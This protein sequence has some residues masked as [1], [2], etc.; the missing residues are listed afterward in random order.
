MGAQR[1]VWPRFLA[2]HD[3]AFP[4]LGGLIVECHVAAERAVRHGKHNITLS[5]RL[6]GLSGG[7][8]QH[9]PDDLPEADK[10]RCR[11]KHEKER[12]HDG[13][14]RSFG[15]AVTSLGAR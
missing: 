3:R 9:G 11:D 14:A 1:F 12:Q 10:E 2:L 6:A 4:E 7:L 8:A 5:V 15:P 13:E